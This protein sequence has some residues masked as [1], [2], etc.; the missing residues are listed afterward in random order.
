MQTLE[1]TQNRK[2]FG[3]V[4]N[5]E[6]GPTNYLISI[7]KNKPFFNDM[8]VSIKYIKVTFVDA[9]PQQIFW[10]SNI[11]MLYSNGQF[12]FQQI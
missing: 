8:L 6:I 9:R 12:Q 7:N 5:F 3:Q 11:L 2:G 1:S 4:Q 10:E